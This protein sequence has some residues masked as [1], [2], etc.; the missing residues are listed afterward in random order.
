[1]VADDFEKPNGLCFSPDE[2]KLYIVDTAISHNPN[3]PAH[4]RVFDVVDGS[5]LTNGRLFVDMAPGM[6][7]GIRT[8]TDGNVWSSAGWGDADDD[9]VHCFAP[10]GD[11]IGRIHLPEPCSNLCFGGRKKKR[12][13]MTCGQ[14]IYALYVEACGTQTP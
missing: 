6:A 11:L 8:D 1:M 13:F 5:R 9:G 7:D 12:L 14:S 2:S 3:G 4:I 10:S